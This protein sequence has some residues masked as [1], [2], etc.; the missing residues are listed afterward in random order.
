MAGRSPGHFLWGDCLCVAATAAS[1]PQ[2]NTRQNALN[3]RFVAAI[4]RQRGGSEFL[5]NG[6]DSSALC[7]IETAGAASP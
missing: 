1:L 3:A 4:L 6:L 2:E 5:G 7:Q